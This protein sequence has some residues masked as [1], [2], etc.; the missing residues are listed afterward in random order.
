MANSNA[1]FGFGGMGQGNFGSPPPEMMPTGYYLN[2]LTSEYK[3]APKL[4]KWMTVVLNVFQDINICLAS[5]VTA[6]NINYAVGEQLDLLGVIVGVN[7]TVRFQPSNN[8]SPVLDD[9][10]YRVVLLAKIA[11]NHWNGRINS[12]YSIWQTLFPGGEL[13]I[14]D[15][16]N[17]TAT[18]F[19]TGTF[20]SI[21]RDLIAGFALNGATSGTI[22]NG[23]IIP[24]PETVQY[25]FDF[26]TLPAFGVDLNNE[27]VAGP[28]LGHVA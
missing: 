3:L 2:L 4:Q 7:R 14:H 28:D 5:F 15:N 13:I 18:I 27:Y 16:Q 19:L 24:K 9:A 8:V 6:F 17:M 12:L 21:L 1:N 20:T 11:H 22:H 25:N 23:Y 10:T 26:G